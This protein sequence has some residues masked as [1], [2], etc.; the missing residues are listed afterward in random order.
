MQFM[1]WLTPEGFL[2]LFV[3]IGRN[4]QGVGTSPFATYVE[5]VEKQELPVDEKKAVLDTID[6]IYEVMDSV[7]GHFMDNEGGRVPLLSQC[8]MKSK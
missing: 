4:S 1:Q 5:N 8:F 3:L 6:H 7:I 2:K